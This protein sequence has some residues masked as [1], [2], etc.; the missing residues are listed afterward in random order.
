MTSQSSI[1][2]CNAPRFDAG[3]PLAE[4]GIRRA[5]WLTTVMMVV[6]IAGGWW[7]NSMAVLADGWHMSS[8][9]I[10]LGLSAF[11]Y[12][13]A[14]RQARHRAFAFG[15]WKIEVLGGYTS[16]ILLLAVAALMVFQSVGRLLTPTEIH[17]REAIVIAVVG[18]VVNLVC[19]YWLRGSHHGHDHSHDHA[20]E[21]H[22]Q[23]ADVNLRSAYLH[24]VADA[25]TSVLAIVALAGGMLWGFAWLDPLMGLVGAALVSIWAWGLLRDSSRILLDAEMDSP[26]VAEVRAAIERGAVP[27]TITDLHVWRV[28]REKYAVMV[29]LTTPSRE[30]A[31]YFRQALRVHQELVH[32]TVEVS[33]T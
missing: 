20:D 18:L 13:Y 24:V 9:A 31:D 7:F 28:G 10:A 8:H 14:R 25:A 16:A 26:V 21:H 32:V 6:E 12:S 22:A 3:N 23:H 15:T 1:H 17:Y 11:A 27:A 4:R 29:S 33:K 5:L 2:H 19:V 30:D